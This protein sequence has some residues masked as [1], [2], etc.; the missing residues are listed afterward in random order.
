M[1][2]KE[3][4]PPFLVRCTVGYQCCDFI[5]LPWR[6]GRDPRQVAGLLDSQGWSLATMDMPDG[7]TAKGPCCAAC[8]KTLIQSDAVGRELA[9]GVT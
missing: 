3:A 8:L 1:G 7:T 5:L 4:D 9:R 6:E 2:A